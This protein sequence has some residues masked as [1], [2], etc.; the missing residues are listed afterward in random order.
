MLPPMEGLRGKTQILGVGAQKAGTSTLHR[1]LEK[2]PGICGTPLKEMYFF[3]SWLMPELA[4]A[5]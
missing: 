5:F 1:Y 3:D 4:G 2:A